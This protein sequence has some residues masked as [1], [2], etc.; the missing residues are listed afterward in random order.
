MGFFSLVCFSMS[1][2]LAALIT[3]AT[4]MR[5][6]FQADLY[7]YEEWVKLFAFWLYFCGA[8]YG[9]FNKSHVSADLVTAYIPEGGF[10]RFLAFLK[11]LVTFAVTCLFLYYGYEFFMFGFRGPLG[12]GIA[13][14]MTTIW[15]IPLWTSYLAITL[16][17]FF[18]AWYF[19]VALLQS[20]K[21]LLKGEK[22]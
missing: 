2:L 10:K 1:V 21:A 4:L 8:G 5:Y 17:L 18:M 9:A 22:A 13:L 14:P 11:D 15:R 16:G 20:A 12:T 19:G 6:V 7:G 3:A